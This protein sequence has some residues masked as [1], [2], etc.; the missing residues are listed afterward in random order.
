[1]AGKRKKPKLKKLSGHGNIHQR[2]LP[3]EKLKQL[4][5]KGRTTI[6]LNGR[7]RTITPCNLK[8]GNKIEYYKRSD[9]GKY[10]LRNFCKDVHSKST[11]KNAKK[12]GYEG[13]TRNV[14]SRGGW[15]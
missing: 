2:T 4:K 10:A 9:T 3:A 8:A 7:K 12:R 6:T 1:M 11:H 15:L 13:D 14:K 5:E